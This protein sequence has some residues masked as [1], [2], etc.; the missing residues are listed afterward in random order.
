M[1]LFGLEAACVP[2]LPVAFGVLAP[3]SAG[4]HVFVM[5]LILH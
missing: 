3:V 2:S 4:V 5:S 1:I